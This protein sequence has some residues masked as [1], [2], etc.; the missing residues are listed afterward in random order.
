MDPWW[1][2]A[3][4]LISVQKLATLAVGYLKDGRLSET[5]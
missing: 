5:A 1:N 4:C 3:D 2:G